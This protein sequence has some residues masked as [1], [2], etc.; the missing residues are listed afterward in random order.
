[1]TAVLVPILVV[2]FAVIVLVVVL[3]RMSKRR[4]EV[5]TQLADA[6][7]PSL[8]YHVPEG[9]DPAV[10]L[11]ALH[12]AGFTA[13]TD[14]VDTRHVR[15]WCP[16]GVDRVRAQVRAVIESAGRPGRAGPLRRRGLSSWP[17][18]RVSAR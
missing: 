6:G 12:A 13:G 18:R 3:L 9:H 5:A 2:A 16:G 15:V 17:A 11:A 14:P 8:G 7:T 1:M 4:E 10:P